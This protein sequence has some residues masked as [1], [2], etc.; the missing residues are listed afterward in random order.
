MMLRDVSLLECILCILYKWLA[1]G[2]SAFFKG[3]KPFFTCRLSC[4]RWATALCRPWRTGRGTRPPPLCTAC[5]SCLRR[6]AAACAAT[7][8][9]GCW[10]RLSSPPRCRRSPAWCW[11]ARRRTLIGAREGTTWSA[12]V[13]MNLNVRFLNWQILARNGFRCPL[14]HIVGTIDQKKYLL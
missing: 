1:F 7:A 4:P 14:S 3:S 13:A 9:L 12:E 10:P 2:K 8:W 6:S 5:P 11:S